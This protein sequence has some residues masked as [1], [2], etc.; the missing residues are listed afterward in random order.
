MSK[1]HILNVG[2]GNCIIIQPA[3]ERL[4]VID[5]DNSTIDDEND[6]LTEPVKYIVDNFSDSIFRF[7]L[8]HPDMDHMSG[9]SDLYKKKTICN[10]WDTKTKKTIEDNEW[11]NSPY[12][13]DDWD[14]YQQLKKS[15]ENPKYLTLFQ[16]SSSDCCWIQDKLEILAPTKKTTDL[17]NKTGEYNH[18][19]YV[20]IYEYAGI[21]ILISGDATKEV[22][23]E[24]YNTIG[25]KKLK[26]DIFIAPHHGS[27]N[28]IHEDV[29][30]YIAPDYVIVSV[31]RGKDYAYDYYS[32]LA[33]KK[34]LTTKYYGNITIDISFDGK[35]T[36]YVEKNYES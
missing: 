33:K 21:K 22:W 5:I 35:Y 27:E 12:N 18:T 11:N 14:V 24:I 15:E 32:K 16:G 26:A 8:T 36:L 4:T 34:I 17:A 19:S 9:L 6:T 23:E 20:L 13:K 2:K 1:I 10:F 25:D 30:S 28:N 31:A 29:F 7:I 3:S